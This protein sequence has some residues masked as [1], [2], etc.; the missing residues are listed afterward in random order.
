MTT[1]YKQT[2]ATLAIKIIRIFFF[3]IP[4]PVMACHFVEV[5]SKNGAFS[6]AKNDT[7]FK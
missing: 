5:S 1:E 6:K 7:F 2:H 3:I 4:F